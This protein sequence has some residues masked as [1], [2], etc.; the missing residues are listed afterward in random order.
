MYYAIEGTSGAID[1]AQKYVASQDSILFADDCLAD[2]DALIKK[3]NG[4]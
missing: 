4:L 1:F 2:V 3:T